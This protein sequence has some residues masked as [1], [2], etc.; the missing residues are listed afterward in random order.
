[1]ENKSVIGVKTA[2]GAFYPILEQDYDGKKKFILTTIRDNQE[3]AQI[4][5]FQKKTEDDESKQYVGSLVIE[6]IQEALKGE[7]EIEVII[8]IDSD[9]NL[10]AIACDLA[11]G[12]KQ[13]LTTSLENLSEDQ[14]LDVP[15]FDLDEPSDK[16]SEVTMMREPDKDFTIAEDNTK[17][18]DNKKES[19][20]LKRIIFILIGLIL[21]AAI[22]FL[23]FFLISQNPSEVKPDIEERV[24]QIEETD[25]IQIVTT[26]ESDK[27]AEDETAQD[28]ADNATSETIQN[29]TEQENEVIEEEEKIEEQEQTT[30]TTDV[31]DEITTETPKT[32]ETKGATEDFEYIIKWGDTLWDL[33]AT[34]YRDPFLY[35]VIA[36]YEKNNISNP[37]LI[38]ANTIIYIPEN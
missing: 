4:D 16:E 34:F 37:D 22:T 38:L 24:E 19:N 27:I 14:L 9:G 28:T 11:T 18:T 15:D 5:L 36:N 8:G 31:P 17:I 29:E 35:P 6:N 23:I 32:E 30:E 13:R 12:N 26:E 2:D 7:P 25:S 20:P 10:N 33:A 1:M 21:I 3:T